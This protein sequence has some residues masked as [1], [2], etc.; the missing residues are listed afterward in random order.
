MSQ[1]K[2]DQFIRNKFIIILKN[3]I[4]KCNKTLFQKKYYQYLIT[5]IPT[6]GI[7]ARR[8]GNVK[9]QIKARIPRKYTTTRKL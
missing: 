6:N 3:K 8:S 1:S 2:Y 4:I 9:C 5:C 7:R